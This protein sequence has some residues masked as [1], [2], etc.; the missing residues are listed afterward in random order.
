M[1]RAPLAELPFWPRMLSR[2]EAARYLG[3]S[4]DVFDQEVRSG[5]WPPAQ[6]RGAKGGRVTWDRIMLDKAADRA[7]GL[8]EVAGPVAAGPAHSEEEAARALEMIHA[9]SSRNRIEGH[10]RKARGR[11]NP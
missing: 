10:A 1:R 11:L 5:L 6:R 9:T 8:E 2:E 7:S 4:D 3:V